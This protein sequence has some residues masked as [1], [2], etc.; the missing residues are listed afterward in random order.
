ML[1]QY[2]SLSRGGGFQAICQALSAYLETR[3]YM[4]GNDMT[5]ADLTI[6]GQLSSTRQW[7][8]ISRLPSL[9][10]LRRWFNTCLSHDIVAEVYKVAS[11]GQVYHTKQTT[12]QGKENESHCF[13]SLS[14]D[15]S[16]EGTK[17]WK[18]KI[19]YFL[20]CR[21]LSLIN[22]FFPKRIKNWKNGER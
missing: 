10:H 6:L 14:G 11:V 3:T 20:T 19:N 15:P 5:V 9:A 1:D 16:E 17:I 7:E 18:S 21:F 2:N 22:N 13:Y 12:K 8:A 4:V